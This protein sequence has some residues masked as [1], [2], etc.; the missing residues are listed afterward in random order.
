M[1]LR[2]IKQLALAFVAVFLAGAATATTAQATTEG[3]AYT[4]EEEVLGGGTTKEVTATDAAA[5]TLRN[6]TEKI[7]VECRALKLKP[8]AT[9]N[10][11]EPGSSGTSNETL[12]LSQCEGGAKEESLTGC[13]PEGG[14][15][16]SVA[17]QNTLGFASSTRTGPLL[18]LVA[19]EAGTTLATVKFTGGKC[20]S[21][22]ATLSGKLIGA[23]YSGGAA[24]EAGNNE[25]ESVKGELRFAS[26]GK[27]IWLESSG[28]LSSVKSTLTAFETEATL[29][30][31]AGLE[32]AS[33]QLWA[34]F[35]TTELHKRAFSFGPASVLFTE[36][37][38]QE[39]LF[40]LHNRGTEDLELRNLKLVG[41]QASKYQIND[42]NTC[43]IKTFVILGECGLTIKLLERHAGAA[44]LEGEVL[45][46][47]GIGSGVHQAF[48]AK[49]LIND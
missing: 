16:T 35:A 25:V 2:T 19:P 40:T 23:A 21:A 34:P 26:A 15:L 42:K 33:K 44:L 22:S 17:L 32:L 11:T 9:L 8:G 28:S 20:V 24:V 30:G 39:R 14:K 6:K 3:P 38:G 12:E 13:E 18:V 48:N 1:S 5:F 10:G 37:E 49:A 36:V 43:T 4:V 29:E 46:G 27:T 7:K 47:G 41:S 31:Q 45:F